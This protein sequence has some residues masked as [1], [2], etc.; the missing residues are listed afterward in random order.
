MI[1]RNDRAFF[2]KTDL[3]DYG[4]WIYNHFIIKCC[5]INKNTHGYSRNF[6]KL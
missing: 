4:V 5:V 2:S 6:Y 1:D 3:N